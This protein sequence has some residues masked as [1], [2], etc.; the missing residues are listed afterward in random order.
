MRT[1]DRQF[2]SLQDNETCGYLSRTIYFSC[3]S[4]DPHKLH[5]L[6]LSS[7]LEVGCVANLRSKTCQINTLSMASNC[8][9]QPSNPKI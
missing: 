9:P 3:R 5:M 1:R 2:M 7:S 6:I 4:N 8:E